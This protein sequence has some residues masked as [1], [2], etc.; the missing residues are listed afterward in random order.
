MPKIMSNDSAPVGT[1]GQAL[2][3]EDPSLITAPAPNC[4]SSWAI[5]N[6]S[7]LSSDILLFYHIC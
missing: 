1:A 2:T 7:V 6:S 5:A 3:S 4:L